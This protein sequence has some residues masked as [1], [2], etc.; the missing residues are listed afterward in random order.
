LTG[1]LLEKFEN[2]IKA[3]TLV[4]SHGGRF[5]VRCDGKLVYSKL[6]TGRHAHPGEISTLLQEYLEE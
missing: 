1:E 4:P 6:E 2:H 5:E 3:L